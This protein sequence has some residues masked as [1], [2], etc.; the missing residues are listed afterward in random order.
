MEDMALRGGARRRRW[1]QHEFGAVA[2]LRIGRAD[3]VAQPRLTAL[4]DL[5]DDQAIA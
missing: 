2:A 4:R 1:R 3:F 5:A